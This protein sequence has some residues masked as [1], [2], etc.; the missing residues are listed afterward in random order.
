[1][2]ALFVVVAAVA[3]GAFCVALVDRGLPWSE[4]IVWGAGLGFALLGLVGFV[5]ASLL[6][7]TGG[8]VAGAAL[9]VAAVP[10]A[11]LHSWKRP[12][13]E[14]R[15]R[16]RK[17]G[18][19]LNLSWPVVAY[20][21]A[22]F[23]LFAAFFAQA[24]YERDGAIAT[25]E[26]NNLGDLGFHVGII[27]GFVKGENFPPEHP[28]Y[29]GA[30]LTYPFLCDFITALL[31]AAGAPMLAAMFWQNLVLA[32]AL[33]GALYLWA[34]ELTRDRLA[35][36]LAPVVVCF[37]GGLGF[38]TFVMEA[39]KSGGSALR[40][41]LEPPHAVTILWGQYDD[42]LRWGNA[43]TTF[44]LPQRAWLVGLPLA[45][46]V[47]VLWWRARHAEDARARARTLFVAG[48][49]A[50]LL[51]LAHAHTFMVL[52]GMGGCLALLYLA[53]WRAWA[54][55]FVAASA[56]GLPQVYWVTREAGASAGSFLAWH[57]GWARPENVSMPLLTFWLVNTGLT[58]PLAIAAFVWRRPE[59][60]VPRALAV[61]LAPFV[62]CLA[63]PNVIK[64]SPWEW[65]TNKVL[66]YGYLAAVLPLALLLARLFR[67]P[68]W[69]KAA[70]AAALVLLTL[71]GAVDVWRV[72]SG[73]EHHVQFDADTIAQARLI[74][75][76]APPRARVLSAFSASRATLVAG[77]R[78]LAGHPWTMWSHGFAA[79]ARMEDLKKIYAG[80]PEA[81]A[82]VA[83]YRIDFI[84]VGPT[85]RAELA[86][87]D[88]WLD[89]RFERVGEA[90]GA[91]LYKTRRG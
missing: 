56:L 67:G 1:M 70:A 57:Y 23:I 22:F 48:L 61:F 33:L 12:G 24:A 14:P 44:F 35:A 58:F 25:G 87:N 89:A 43:L 88:A 76:H 80:S 90:G 40:M 45:L 16:S 71:S 50:G 37:C 75:A 82:L 86:P 66:F 38:W 77:R 39:Q 28:E 83:Q 27:S 41:F 20:F 11:A 72:V 5:A 32:L 54:M 19:P 60:T 52:M 34:F 13:V 31:V 7:L 68:V 59:P 85:E 15:R 3:G 18:A 2:L 64:L 46:Y 8:V 29:A 17:A 81:D 78:S 62:L 49:V 55:F 69:M 4:R 91:V 53:H 65:D 30:R 21:A 79:D 63:A 84:L 47:W 36:L 74:E 42:I 6:G 26:W 51:P 73:R 10:A 9:V